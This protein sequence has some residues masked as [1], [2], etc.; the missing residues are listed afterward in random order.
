[1]AGTTGQF[2]EYSSDGQK[3]RGERRKRNNGSGQVE[4]RAHFPVHSLPLVQN[5]FTGRAGAELLRSLGK[6]RR[7]SSRRRLT[8]SR[9]ACSRE[10]D[11]DKPGRP[12]DGVVATVSPR[13]GSMTSSG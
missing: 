2:S 5:H 9:I 10:D 7:A 8:D 12:I 4:L 11:S 3:N 1:M 6:G 13:P